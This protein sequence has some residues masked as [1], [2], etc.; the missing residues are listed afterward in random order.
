MIR[1]GLDKPMPVFLNLNLKLFQLG[2]PWFEPVTT[3]RDVSS[4]EDSEPGNVN[5]LHGGCHPARRA[6]CHLLR[7]LKN[8]QQS[9][10][11]L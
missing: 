10:P 3:G 1:F 4:V 6:A 5:H 8:W 9:G 11:I 7:A 2:L